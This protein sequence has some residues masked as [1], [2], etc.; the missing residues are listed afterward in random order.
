MPYLLRRFDHA[1]M[2]NVCMA[3]W[4]YCWVLLPGLNVLARMGAVEI[5]GV[6]MVIGATKALLW[7]C[8]YAQLI[9]ARVACLSYSCV[10]RRRSAL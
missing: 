7:V 8:I 1:R 3:I 2:Y 5:E 10:F 9:L 6:L 4:P